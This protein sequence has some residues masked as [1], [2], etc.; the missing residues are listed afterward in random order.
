MPLRLI[1]FLVI[2]PLLAVAVYFLT[3]D[4][5]SNQ[6]AI[7]T[8]TDVAVLTEETIAFADLAHELQRERG[9]T[10][11]FISSGGKNFVREL[12]AQ[13]E[14]TDTLMDTQVA[15]GE[16]DAKALVEGLDALRAAID[17]GDRTVP[18]AVGA[19][20]GFIMALL[21]NAH[22][23]RLTGST[24]DLKSLLLA[25]AFLSTAKEL[26]GRERAMGATGL[27]GGFAPDTL[28]A[29]QSNGAGQLTLLTEA[30]NILVNHDLV[31]ALRATPEW[32]RIE[33]ARKTVR[34]GVATGTY[35]D[36]VAPD[37]FRLSTDWIETLRLQ[38]L[39]LAEEISA[40]SLLDQK[41]AQSR[42]RT[43]MTTAL[44]AIGA[45]LIFAV[46]I[47]ETLIRRINR[48]RVTV[49][50]MTQGSYE[51]SLGRI[52][53]R[54]ELTRMARAIHDFR[55]ETLRMRDGAQ[56]LEA[57]QTR[58]GAEQAEVMAIFRSKLSRLAEGD[59][60][61]RIDEPVPDSY[62]E[63][64]D[65]YNAAVAQLQDTM[66]RLIASASVIGRR[67][68]D[69]RGASDSL[70]QRTTSQA[71]TLEETTAALEQVASSVRSAADAARNVDHVTSK[72]RSDA[73]SSS[74]VVREAV[75]EMA[76]VRKS[77]DNIVGIIDVIDDIAFQTNLLALNA[78]VEAA[79][80]GEA[81]KGFAVV[82]S[83]V[84]QLAQRASES[85]AQIKGLIGESADQ[86]SRGVDMVEEA[87][88]ALDLIVGH[89]A[90]ISDLVADI[91]RSAQEQSTAISEINNGANSLDQVTQENAM[92]ANEMQSTVE[93]LSDETETLEQMTGR[94]RVGGAAA[95]QAP[96]PMVRSA[97]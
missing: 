54:D 55:D 72:A 93:A 57:E 56:A 41:V 44:V 6:A 2:A 96:A 37:W 35:G 39:A 80:A 59:L 48:M 27:G 21:D 26:A 46:L 77:S 64:R 14:A 22:P 68:R 38:E 70:S 78:G 61:D 40:R 30:D 9:Y 66:H 11:G 60:T 24:A 86:V 20:T 88:S 49:D 67:A 19:Y 91:A 8:A 97:A 31:D 58:R 15:R 87:G 45:S 33:A 74:N 92:M 23:N 4:L 36:L 53:G 94:F 76:K 89:I 63:M 81:G 18:Q 83:E 51:A 13:R 47:F 7:R 3:L 42:S 1:M 71:A 50:G 52:E 12:P 65:D 90:N 95:A 84:R 10:A 17:A 32:T 29:F 28:N 5:R 75:S 82:A 79:R 85:A 34:D 69:I 25:R 62:V 16:Q 73:S 43:V